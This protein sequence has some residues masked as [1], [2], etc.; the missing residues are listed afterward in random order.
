LIYLSVAT[1]INV[2]VDVILIR[3]IGL[4]G[5]AYGTLVTA[6]ALVAMSSYGLRRYAHVTLGRSAWILGV[7]AVT[8][9]LVAL[10]IRNEFGSAVGAAVAGAFC[11]LALGQ[12]ALADWR[13]GLRQIAAARIPVV[14]ST[15]QT[16]AK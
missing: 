10:L 14:G 16:E 1:V 11:W 13:S 12:F 4:I 6:I 2:V 3:Q 5:A 15:D 8:G 7:A 9:A